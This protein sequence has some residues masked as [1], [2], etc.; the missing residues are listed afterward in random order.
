MRTIALIAGAGLIVAGCAGG[1]P[2]PMTISQ[3]GVQT[4]LSAM[5]SREAV[6]YW[7]SLSDDLQT[8]IAAEFAGSFDPAGDIITVDIDELSMSETY[9]ASGS[10]EDAR[11]SGLVTVE[12]ADGTDIGAYNV[13]AS[14]SDLVNYLP[15]GTD[16]ATVRPTD[17]VYYDAI[18]QAFAR[19]TADAIRTGS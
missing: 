8:A 19:G 18:V 10:I 2:E 4:D 7:Q 13:T 17:R 11:L 1:E 14:S 5:Q 16:V 3:V 12:Q 9:L 15:P 6:G